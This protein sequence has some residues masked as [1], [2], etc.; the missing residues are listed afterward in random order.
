MVVPKSCQKTIL[1]ELHT[2][3]LSIVRMKS[4]ART[5]VWWPSI[6][7]HIEQVVHDRPSCQ[8]IWNAPSRVEL[9]PWSWPDA[10]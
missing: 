8:S 7:K 1:A 4:I 6:D 5:H 9:Y 3:H 2:S 10:P